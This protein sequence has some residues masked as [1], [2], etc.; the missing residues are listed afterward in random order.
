[1]GYT[2][3]KGFLALMLKIQL[4]YINLTI[5]DAPMTSACLVFSDFSLQL[6]LCAVWYCRRLVV[7]CEIMHDTEESLDMRQLK[8]QYSGLVSS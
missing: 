6:G 7:L 8:R 2:R 4:L 1:M 5:L 3:T